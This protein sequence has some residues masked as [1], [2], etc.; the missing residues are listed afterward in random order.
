M[1]WQYGLTHT[2][3]FSIEIWT[4]LFSELSCGFLYFQDLVTLP[5]HIHTEKVGDK[6][7][8]LQNLRVWRQMKIKRLLLRMY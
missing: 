2:N 6:Q 1:K 3:I 5:R 8:Q 7:G 4:S